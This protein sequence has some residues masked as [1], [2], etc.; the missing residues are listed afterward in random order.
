METIKFKN[1]DYEIVNKLDNK[2]LHVKRNDKDFIIVPFDNVEAF[3]AYLTNKKLLKKNKVERSKVLKKDKVALLVLEQFIKG[4]NLLSI[5]ASNRLDDVC[6]KELFRVYRNNRFAQVLLS[7][8][9]ENFVK[10]KKYFYYIS[11][12]IMPLSQGIAFERGDDILLWLNTNKQKQYVINKGYQ[13]LDRMM[14][15]SEAEIK[16]KIALV[17]VANW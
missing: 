6:L 11:D 8:K 17:C 5:I 13:Y 7:Y 9:P 10:H 12:T 2:K 4:E 3:N 16:K 14:L 15:T 1:K